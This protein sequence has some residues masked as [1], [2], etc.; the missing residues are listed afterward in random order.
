MTPGLPTLANSITGVLKTANSLI[1][2]KSDIQTAEIA[3]RC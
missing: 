1:M 2:M 3:K